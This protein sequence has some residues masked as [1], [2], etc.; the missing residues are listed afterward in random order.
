[1][2]FE[3]Y[4]IVNRETLSDNRYAVFRNFGGNVYLAILFDGKAELG[5][6]V[7]TTNTF[8]NRLEAIRKLEERLQPTH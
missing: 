8:T 3:Q 1:M 4:P 6:E 7:Y 5:V 2:T